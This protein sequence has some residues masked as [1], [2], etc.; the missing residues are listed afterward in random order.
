MQD[1]FFMTL[2]NFENFNKN[3][4]NYTKVEKFDNLMLDIERNYGD[5]DSID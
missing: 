1:H 3:S 4:E 5:S 2:N